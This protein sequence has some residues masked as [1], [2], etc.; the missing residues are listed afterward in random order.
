V[1]FLAWTNTLLRRLR[2]FFQRMN[3]EM[4]IAVISDLYEEE[5]NR[6]NLE[7]PMS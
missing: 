4:M 6:Y 7:L 5:F 1:V 2:L 3:V